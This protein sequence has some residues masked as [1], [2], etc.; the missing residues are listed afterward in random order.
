MDLRGVYESILAPSFPEGDIESCDDIERDLL[1]GRASLLVDHDDDHVAR[2]A[3]VVYHLDG[4]DLLGHIAVSREHRS[5]GIG[6]DMVRVCL[7]LASG[8]G[9]PL[10]ALIERPDRHDYHPEFGDPKRRIDFYA[11]N[12]ARALDLPFCQP[13]A[14]DDARRFGML[15][16]RLDDGDPDGW[17]D[18]EPLRR[19]IE[20]YVGDVDDRDDHDIAL[21]A[22]LKMPRVRL[23][24]M[25]EYQSILSP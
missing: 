8:R 10:L 13:S 23:I 22:A 1:S 7:D 4:A 25:D 14:K 17:M 20:D 12:G 24:P 19:F 11:D 15:L 16:S 9:V 6:G 5:K 18:A 2:A 21:R 3:A